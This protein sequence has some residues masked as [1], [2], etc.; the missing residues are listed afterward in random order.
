[1]KRKWTDELQVPSSVVEKLEGEMIDEESFVMLE[2]NDLKEMGIPLG[3]RKI[4]LKRIEEGKAR[5]VVKEVV[6][7]TPEDV[8]SAVDEDEDDE[9]QNASES[10]PDIEI[11]AEEALENEMELEG[12][13]NG[14]IVELKCPNFGLDFEGLKTLL[15]DSISRRLDL[16]P[17]ED[18]EAAENPHAPT[19]HP[20]FFAHDSKTYQFRNV[21][22]LR[23]DSNRYAAKAARLLN[24][25][26]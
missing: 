8:V 16:P 20:V 4:L 18:S 23:F 14:K 15:G 24:K 25:T 12:D 22:Y 3:P 17:P 10:K 2:D 9:V 19:T 13:L 5:K 6:V 11:E 26:V 7:D 1:M 21:I